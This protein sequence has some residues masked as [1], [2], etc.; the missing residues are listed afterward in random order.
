MQKQNQEGLRKVWFSTHR[1]RQREDGV[2]KHT[3]RHSAF[4]IAIGR[5]L[6]FSSGMLSGIGASSFIGS[7]RSSTPGLN[8]SPTSTAVTSSLCSG[9]ILTNFPNENVGV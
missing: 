6:G 9:C 4:C 3:L 1:L 8:T 2:P 7:N 5:A